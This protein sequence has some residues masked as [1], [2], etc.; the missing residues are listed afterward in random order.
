MLVNRDV[1]LLGSRKLTLCNGRTPTGRRFGVPGGNG[2]AIRNFSLELLEPR[3]LLAGVTLITHGYEP[4]SDDLPGW[5]SSMANSVASR[6]GPGT[7]IYDLRVALNSSG[8]AQVASFT[9]VSG[10]LFSASE[11]GQA[12]IMLDW[13]DASGLILSY[14]NTATIAQLVEPYLMDADPSLGITS[15]LADLPIHLI[16]HSRGASV[17]SQLAMDLGQSGIWVDQLTTLDPHPVDP[18][19]AVDVYSNVVFADNYYETDSLT[20]G[21]AIAGAYNVNL[22]GVFPS[23]LIDQHE[24]VHAYYD[25]TVDTS[26]S[27]DGDGITID[28]AWYDFQGTGPRDETGFYYS[29]IGGGTRPADGIG[30]GPGST[31]ARVVVPNVTGSPWANVEDVQL[32]NSGSQFQIGQSLHGR[33]L[34]QDSD[35]APNVSLWLDSDQNPLDG[36]TSYEVANPSLRGGTS[37][38]TVQLNMSGVPAGQYYLMANIQNSQSTRYAYDSTPITLTNP[39][40]ALESSVNVVQSDIAAVAG[41]RSNCSVSVSTTNDG[42]S[43]F[44]GRQKL[45]LF[46]SIDQTLDSSDTPLK[47]RTEPLNLKADSEKILT[48]NV[49]LPKTLAA[50]TYYIL[51]ELTDLAGS[52]TLLADGTVTL[53]TPIIQLSDSVAVTQTRAQIAATLVISNGGNIIATGKLQLDFFA[54]PVGTSGPS[55]VALPTYTPMIY[56]KPQES[57]PLKKRMNPSKTLAAGQYLLVAELLPDRVFNIGEL[58]AIAAVSVGMFTVG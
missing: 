42:D 9:Q 45:Q 1:M 39:A 25:G 28:P 20:P 41:Q 14:T 26:A 38:Q 27:D 10:P 11:N 5:V 19:P 34:F 8:V 44:H 36:S 7:A 57:K 43:L 48:L 24:D 6:A 37:D 30:I 51:A 46:A 33:F 35:S 2:S 22:S 18:D 56:I 21:H 23:G 16:G 49:P 50:G 32:T 17:V 52:Q 53:A 54:R 40:A 4:T 13:A 58:P 31:A 3:T 47:S 15:P 55:D 12:V 29:L